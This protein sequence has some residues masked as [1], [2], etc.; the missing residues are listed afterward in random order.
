MWVYHWL[1]V[2]KNIIANVLN[3]SLL[4]CLYCTHIYIHVIPVWVSHPEERASSSEI[5]DLLRVQETWI[6]RVRRASKPLFK[7]AVCCNTPLHNLPNSSS[8]RIP[9]RT[10][11][12]K[13]K[14]LS[15]VG[16]WSVQT[17][18]AVENLEKNDTTGCIVWTRE[19]T[20]FYTSEGVSHI[21]LNQTLIRSCG[22]NESEG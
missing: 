13:M 12:E 22:R 1:P 4:N 9:S 5:R 6:K 11:E 16:Q 7:D 14:R 20:A 2:A 18:E 3:H 21:I 10:K 15:K 19:K 17:K 8:L